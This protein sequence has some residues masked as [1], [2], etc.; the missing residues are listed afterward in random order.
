MSLAMAESLPQ[1]PLF[2][3]ER[4]WGP[5]VSP[6]LVHQFYCELSTSSLTEARH[7]S[8]DKETDWKDI[9][10]TGIGKALATVVRRP[11]EPLHCTSAIY[12]PGALVHPVYAIWFVA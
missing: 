4:L 7:G 6:K 11:S 1:S 10:P 3:F 9:P 12:V 5:Q 2:L 8:P